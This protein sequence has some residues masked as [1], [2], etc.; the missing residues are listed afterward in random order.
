MCITHS[1]VQIAITS[2]VN[3]STTLKSSVFQKD[4]QKFVIRDREL[5]DEF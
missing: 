3:N 2:S 5:T 4:V 1:R